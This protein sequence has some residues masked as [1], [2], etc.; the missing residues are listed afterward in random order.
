MTASSLAL[1][2]PAWRHP[3]FRRG[4]ADMA[5]IAL[6]IAAW[7]L[8]T[9]VAMVKSGLGVPLSVLMSLTVY[10]GSAQ[11]AALPLIASGAPI[12][13]VWATAFCVNLR[14]VIFSA[15]WRPYFAHLPLATRLRLGYLTADLNYVLFMRRFPEPKPAPE[16]QPYFWGG[17][18]INWLSWQS[19]S[20]V[21]IF[22]ADRVPTAWGIGFAGTIALLG[23]T[24]SL[25][26]DRA[27]W[28][29]A[30]VA[31]CAA[32]AAYAMPLRLNIVVAIAAAVAIA[33]LIDHAGPKRRE[34]AA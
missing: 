9:G 15:Q 11:L 34:G 27:S 8:V 21:G 2:A 13:V 30:A 5:G 22:L 19:T 20:L 18:A 16:Q 26:H 6:G 7:G 14:F 24:Y 3:E 28:I 29:A 17:A 33:L 23:L 1:D 12:W 25:L 32:V 31:G 10:A 4:A